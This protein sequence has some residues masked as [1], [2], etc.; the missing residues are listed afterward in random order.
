[1]RA[2]LQRVSNASVTVEG[3]IIGQIEHGLLI[4]VCAMP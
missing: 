2:L 4:F 3:Q 1:M